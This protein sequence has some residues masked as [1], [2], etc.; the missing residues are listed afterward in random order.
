MGKILSFRLDKRFYIIVVFILLGFIIRYY[1]SSLAD[2]R[3]GF[4]TY[5]YYY[6]AQDM[7]NNKWGVTYND[8]NSGYGFILFF[9]YTI[10]GKENLVNMANLQIIRFIQIG[11]DLINGLLI[12]KICTKIF[13]RRAAIISLFLYLVN[14]FS[15]SFTGLLLPEIFTIF[16]ILLIIYIL[17]SPLFPRS[18]LLWFDLGF[19]LGSLLFIR[20]AFYYYIFALLTILS[21][22]YF[23]NKARIMFILLALVGF[24]I[25][26]SYS[27][28][29]YYHKYQKISLVTPYNMG[30]SMV[31]LNFYRT[32]RFPELNYLYP[33]TLDPKFY[34]IYSEY[35]N[36]PYLDIPKYKEK[37][38]AL[39]WQE[40]PDKWPLFMRSYFRNFFWMWDKEHLATYTDPFYPKD[41]WILRITNML[42]ILLS[43]IGFRYYLK[44]NAGKICKPFII[45]TV[46]FFLYICLFFPL[47]TSETR[48]TLPFYPLIFIFAG[49][50]LHKLFPNIST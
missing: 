47:V 14:P 8:H 17:T 11:V 19:L 16:F 36:L 24:L 9:I 32:N 27:L 28:L 12:Y 50:G 35:H 22:I 45:F 4:D 34:A 33:G 18:K 41:Q 38:T 1:L 29:A 40:F 25:A 26:S 46:S 37:Y 7:F 49:I 42:V 20:M 21:L 31:Y 10:F 43:I 3:S 30:L 39:L 15:A 13:N 5:A 48:H 2:S 6:M 44:A 23:R